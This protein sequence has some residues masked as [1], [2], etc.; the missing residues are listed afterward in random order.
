MWSI[1][2]FWNT[3]NTIS[4]RWTNW[5]LVLQKLANLLMKSTNIIMVY[6]RVRIHVRGTHLCFGTFIFPH[7]YL[8]RCIDVTA[9]SEA[10]AKS[11]CISNWIDLPVLHQIW[12]IFII[13]VT[14]LRRRSPIFYAVYGFWIPAAWCNFAFSEKFVKQLH[15]INKPGFELLL[16]VFPEFSEGQKWI[17]YWKISMRTLI[18]LIILQTFPF[19]EATQWMKSFW[20]SF[21]PGIRN[22]VTL[23]ISST[24]LKALHVDST[25]HQI[26]LFT[27]FKIRNIGTLIPGRVP[28]K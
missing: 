18:L 12:A 13:F 1:T 6:S 11:I 7:P 26:L 20:S 3:I 4:E 19:P 10:V 27:F 21:Q 25:H 22:D 24:T 28:L 17:Q 8:V 16:L 9:K 5:I 14:E 23:R 2:L 15:S